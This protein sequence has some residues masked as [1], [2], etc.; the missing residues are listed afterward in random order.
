MMGRSIKAFM[1]H[2]LLALLAAAIAAPALAQSEDPH[3]RRASGGMDMQWPPAGI[4]LPPQAP[5]P[6]ADP[7]AGHDMSAMGGMAGMEGMAGMDHAAM[8][9]S[10]ALGSY[11]MTREASGT[12]WQPDASTHNGVHGPA[13]DW[14][15]MGHAMINGV[16]DRQGGARGDNKTF[17]AGMVMG[18]A[19]RDLA[20]GD[21]INLRV[22]LS[23]DPLMGKAGYPLL[24]ASGESA[25]G[26]T[27]LIDRQHPHDL[28]M[29]LSASYSRRIDAK[30]SVFVYAGLPGE[31]AFGPPAF[32]H[33]LSTMDSPEAPIT[34][35][36]LDSTHITFGVL[37]GGFIHDN[38]KLEASRFTGREPDQHR[39][40]IESPKMDSTAVRASFNPTANW[41]L[42]ASWADLKSPEALEPS[43]DERR[44][45]ASAIY[46]RKVGAA[47][48][49]STTFAWG[50]K[51]R[52]DGVALDGLALETAL[53]PNADWT[54]FARAEQVE[55]DELDAHAGDPHGEVNRVA[56][57]SLGAIRDWRITPHAKIGLGALVT[58]NKIPDALKHAYGSSPTGGMGFV[59]L[60]VE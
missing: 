3:E 59:R 30:N 48:L 34:H 56:K 44:W 31:P 36:W 24:L 7:H 18:A 49:W 1:Q 47:G 25:D 19:R 4:T 57:A 23:P 26:K 8:P 2:F 22:M 43:V 27:P 5:A 60:V 53:K 55:T 37:T 12:S 32:M 10:G 13:G 54:L 20:G 16:Y 28:I 11:P 39:Y 6:P 41:S 17:L 42:Q 9:M 14:S 58:A 46:T 15:L 29:E 33:R 45:S 52:S 40:D 51:D 50:R 38:W 21:A 35:H